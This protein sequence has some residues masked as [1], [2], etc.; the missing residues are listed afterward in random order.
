MPGACWRRAQCFRR[1]WRR[2]TFAKAVFAL[3]TKADFPKSRNHLSETLAAHGRTPG[4][5]AV[6]LRTANGQ[7]LSVLL[8]WREDGT[9]H[10]FFQMNDI[11]QPHSSIST[12]LRSLF[13]QDEQ[14]R[15]TSEVR[16]VASTSSLMENGCVEDRQFI[17]LLAKR[18]L[19]K[20]L[21][22]SIANA[23]LR[24]DHRLR[25][26]LSPAAPDAEPGQ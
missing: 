20:R 2:R 23:F 8:G 25:M 3:Q 21:I 15:G 1:T 7:W 11:T 10:V 26:A 9:T 16:F 5:F 18:T 19:R 12:A 13:L 17:V 14:A 6:G 22:A 24:N 4:H